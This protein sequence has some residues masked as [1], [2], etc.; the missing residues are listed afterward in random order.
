MRLSWNALSAATQD[1]TLK[2]NLSKFIV[3]PP[4]PL[5]AKTLKSMRTL[6]QETLHACYNDKQAS[7]PYYDAVW[8]QGQTFKV[9]GTHLS[10]PCFSHGQQLYVACSR[11]SKSQNLHVLQTELNR[12][13]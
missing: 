12:L 11:V 10:T 6:I 8:R 3:R 9:V 5:R 7:A 1:V 4:M 2:H 13:T